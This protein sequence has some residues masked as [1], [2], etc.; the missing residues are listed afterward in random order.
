M[1][2]ISWYGVAF[3]CANRGFRGSMA[4]R[5]LPIHAVGVLPL[6]VWAGG[7]TLAGE[8]MS[9]RALLVLV[10]LGL[11]VYVPVYLLQHRLIVRAGATYNA[12][13]GLAVPIVVGV[14]STLLGMAS[15]PGAAQWCAGLLALAAMGVV[16][17]SRSR[18]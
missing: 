2:L 11:V 4:R 6:L 16:V 18:R 13:L 15:P 14:V 1:L 7:A 3:A 8:R 10:V 5:I 12:L 9:L 17:V